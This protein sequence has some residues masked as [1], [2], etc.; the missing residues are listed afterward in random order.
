[1]ESSYENILNEALEAMADKVDQARD[2][3]EMESYI[4]QRR[5]KDALLDFGLSHS[6]SI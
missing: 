3:W 6:V 1:M 2:K 5:N 4:V